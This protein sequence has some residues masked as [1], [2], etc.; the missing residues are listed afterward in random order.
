MK[1]TVTVISS[2]SP[3][4]ALTFDEADNLWAGTESGAVTCGEDGLWTL[5]NTLCG[6]AYHRITS[7]LPAPSGLFMGA[8]RFLPYRHSGGEH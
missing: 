3:I 5:Y 7:L 1:G 4:H 6:L 2:L 8:S